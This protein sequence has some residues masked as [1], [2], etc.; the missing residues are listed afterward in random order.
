MT[1]QATLD[2]KDNGT[3]AV[4]Y[5]ALELSWK[6]WKVLLWSGGRQRGI[7]VAARDLAGLGAAVAKAKVHFGLDPTTRVVSCY[8]AGRDGFWLHRALAGMG[9]ENLVIDSSAIEV[10]RRARNAK[11]DGVD[12]VK[13]MALLRRH[14]A[15]EAGVFKIVR[16]PSEAA[17]DERRAGRELERLKKEKSQHRSRIKSLLA[18]HGLARD[19][20]GGKGWAEVVAGLRVW[21]GRG[22]PGAITAELVREGE[23]LALIESQIAVLV[24][25]RRDRQRAVGAAVESETGPVNDATAKVACQL[26][27]LK[28]IGPESSWVFAREFFAW[29]TFANRRQV[30]AA[31]GLTPTPY[32]SGAS[33]RE[34]GLSKSGNRR[35]RAMAVEIAWMWLRYQ[36]AST[37][38]RWYKARFAAGGARA[39]KVGIVALARKLLIAL[40]RFATDGIVPEGAMLKRA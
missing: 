12:V 31:A 30:A 10:S 21:T 36:P 23:R 5:M 11:S 37:L 3:G 20:I 29:R 34:Q 24:R 19:K 22:L 2:G 33:Q 40:W 27:Q 15:G 13:L 18:L 35:I 14:G 9:I 16:V 38:A 28:A 8:E 26:E 17:E 7:D 1:I 6:I 32:A 39:R 4:L 25:Q